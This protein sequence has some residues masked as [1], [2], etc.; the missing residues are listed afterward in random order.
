MCKACIILD[1]YATINTDVCNKLHCTMHGPL[2]QLS[3]HACMHAA[4]QLHYSIYI[5]YKLSVV[6]ISSL[7]LYA[8]LFL[9]V[10]G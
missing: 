7:G 6:V 1:H 10:R 3:L 8:P 4:E 5:S 2:H 9:I